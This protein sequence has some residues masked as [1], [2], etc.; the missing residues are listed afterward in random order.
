MNEPFGGRSV[1]GNQTPRSDGGR[2]PR[3]G[4]GF[5]GGRG[6]GRGGGHNVRRDTSLIGKSIRIIRV[7]S[8]VTLELSRIALRRWLESSFMLIASLSRIRKCDFC[9]T[10]NVDRSHVGIT[11]EGASTTSMQPMYESSRTPRPGT[12]LAAASAPKRPCTLLIKPPCTDP[13]RP[14]TTTS[15]VV[16]RL[17]MA[18]KLQPMTDLAHRFTQA[19][20]GILRCPTRRR[21]I[22]RVTILTTTMTRMRPRLGQMNPHTPGFA[23]PTDNDY[24]PMT[25][26][27]MYSDY[28]AP[29]P[30]TQ[31]K[32]DD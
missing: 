15:E 2:T 8:R 3:G 25:P 9:T 16:V 23:A 20:T 19:R 29:S 1:K 27:G 5:G 22:L 26:G 21:T 6:G 7:H 30:Y 13:K 24:N 28:A 32:L 10:I 4:G 18:L 31:T 14:C 11:G 12:T 17:I